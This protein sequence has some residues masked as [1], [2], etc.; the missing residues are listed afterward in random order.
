MG[1]ASPAIKKYF[2]DTDF[3]TLDLREHKQFILERILEMGDD[4]AVA[5][6]REHFTREDILDALEHSRRISQKSRNYWN[7]ILSK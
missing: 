1:N 7:F 3:Q 5:W 2:W 4:A 6:M